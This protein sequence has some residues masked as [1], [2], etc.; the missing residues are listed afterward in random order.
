MSRH[1]PLVSICIP[2]HNRAADAERAVAS[3]LAQTY[4]NIEIVVVDDNSSDDTSVR[5][6]ALADE[7]VRLHINPRRLGQVGNRN[8]SIELAQGTLIK[9]L[10]SDDLLE[11]ECVSLMSAPLERDPGVGM[12][13]CRRRLIVDDAPA[14]AVA[15]WIETYG[16]VHAAFGTLGLVNDGA[17][18]LREWL[19]AGLHDN[20]IG[21]P[22]AVMVRRSVLAASGGFDARTALTPDLGLWARIM[23]RT[24]VA[25]I[26]RELVAYRVGIGANSETVAGLASGRNWLE[27]LWTLEA[28][29][30]DAY[31]AEMF[32]ELRRVRADARRE[33]FRTTLRAGRTASGRYP[34]RPYLGYLAARVRAFAR[35]LSVPRPVSE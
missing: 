23:A 18:M 10:D 26:D 12:A 5:I 27:H 1:P 21:E 7:R 9:F 11:P 30:A 13:F 8:R 15:H 29:Y 3:A 14:P 31:I 19:G 6:R 20:W 34:V 4:E 2:T 16:A 22:T 35:P 32:P 25:F 28:L 33:A 24:N 17:L